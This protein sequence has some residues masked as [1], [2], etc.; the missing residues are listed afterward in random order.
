MLA[1]SERNARP[2]WQSLADLI[3]TWQFSPLAEQ[4]GRYHTIY[5]G[6]WRLFRLCQHLG[7]NAGYV[8]ALQKEDLLQMLA[9]LDRFSA[10]ERGKVWLYAYERHYRDSIFQAIRANHNQGTW[11]KRDARPDSQ[12]VFCIDDRE[13]G[14]RRHLEE[15]NPAIETLGAAGFFGVPINYKGLDDATVTPLCPIVVT[16]AHEVREIPRAGDE[17]TLSEA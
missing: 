11:A 17:K 6:G 14:F 2:D 12:I 10:S 7:L 8:E 4:Q 3:L 15:L 16:P 9:I 5:D 1:G 13:E